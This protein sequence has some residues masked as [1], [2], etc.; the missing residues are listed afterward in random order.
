MKELALAYNWNFGHF[1]SPLEKKGTSANTWEVV[2]GVL[3]LQAEGNI[4]ESHELKELMMLV[5]TI[6]Y[7]RLRRYGVFHEADFEP[8]NYWDRPTSSLTNAPA[9]FVDQINIEYS[10]AGPSTGPGTAASS[11]AHNANV[12]AD[13]TIPMDPAA[14]TAATTD[15]I[16]PNP[17]PPVPVIETSD[18]DINAEDELDYHG[19]MI[20]P[21]IS[22]SDQEMEVE[23][24]LQLEVEAEP[25]DIEM[26]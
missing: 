20:I 12:A 18:I 19:A 11:S 25:E 7:P 14:M 9:V 5:L 2:W 21:F 15:P 3:R 4:I 26:E 6:A 16:L 13:N 17:A 22:D 10:V 1:V 8:V 24:M 23:D